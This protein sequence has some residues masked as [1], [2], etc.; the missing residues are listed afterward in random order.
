MSY[1]TLD[2]CCNNC[3]P[4][5]GSTKC[6]LK[7]EG[8][9]LCAPYLST[10]S[11]C[12]PEVNGNICGSPGPSPGPG[13][14]PSQGNYSCNP[15]S[16]Q[17][18]QTSDGKLTKENCTAGCPVLKTMCDSPFAGTFPTCAEVKKH[19]NC[20]KMPALNDYQSQMVTAGCSKDQAK[21]QWNNFQS[22]LCGGPSSGKK[23]FV[24]SCDYHYF[25]C[26][27]GSFGSC[28]IF[29]CPKEEIVK[30]SHNDQVIKLSFS[31]TE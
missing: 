14:S 26:R 28:D 11:S 2:K 9:F 3:T 30:R 15:K 6:C 19:T 16:G 24:R 4:K 5:G 7:S 1:P 18:T 10:P 31:F 20:A 12:T 27:C 17:C 29:T 23:R 8:Q 13:P 22:C 25:G 21:A